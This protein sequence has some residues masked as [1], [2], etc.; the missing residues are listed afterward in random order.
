MADINLKRFVNINIKQHVYSAVKGTRDTVVLLTTEA[1]AATDPIPSYADAQVVLANCPNALRYAKIYFDNGGNNLYVIGGATL[2]KAGIEAVLAT[3]PNEYIVIAFAGDKTN[4]ETIYAAMKQVAEAREAQKEAAASIDSA[5]GIS[6]KILLASTSTASD[7]D[8]VNNFAV[9]FI[10]SDAT[11]EADHS[12]AEMAIAAYLSQINVYG[13]DTVHD[14]AFTREVFDWHC[15][16][17][18]DDQYATIMQN[19]M[20]VTVSLANAYRN[21]GGNCKDGLDLVNSF[22]RII[23]HQ[24]L[25]DR[26]LTVLAQKI[27]NAAGVGKIYTALVQELENYRTCGYLATD[28]FWIDEDL[29]ITYN[30][31]NYTIIEKGTQLQNGYKAVVLPLAS[32]TEED[33]AAHKAP[34]IIVVLADQYGIRVIN[35]TGDII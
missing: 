5:Y 16:D 8:K 19:N 34:P 24:T 29:I 22:V 3:L 18:T 33:K 35:V 7:T 23:L 26:L 21:C 17:V 15:E 4:R 27:K 2:S 13:I 25:T 1:L 6:E 10:A 31:V 11:L 12:G 32:L 20:N 28:K 30:G 9:K 14:Y